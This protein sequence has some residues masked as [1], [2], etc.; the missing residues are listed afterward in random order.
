MKCE[1]RKVKISDS[2]LHKNTKRRKLRGEKGER[3]KIVVF[4]VWEEFNFNQNQ[5]QME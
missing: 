4:M 3:G 5:S 1:G 2:F